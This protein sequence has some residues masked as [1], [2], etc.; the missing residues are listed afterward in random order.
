MNVIIAIDSL[1]GCLTSCQA[2]EAAR[3]AVWERWPDAEVVCLP[4][5]DGGEGFLDA[6]ASL[7]SLHEGGG[8]W[9]RITVEVLDPLM[10]PIQAD[11]LISL[12][13]GE[14]EGGIA[15][16]EL[17]Q[18]SGLA[19]LKP[20][21]RNP[22]IAS[23]YGTGQL[24]ADALRHRPREIVVGLGGSAI[25]DC[26]RGMLEALPSSSFSL[27]KFLIATD[28]TN[29]LLG[30]QGA[31]HTFARQKSAPSLSPQTL[32]AMVDELEARASAFAS[33]SARLLGHDCS[34]EPGAGAAGGVGYALMQYLGAQRLSGIDY[35][36][37]LARFD[38]LLSTADLIITG[39]GHADRQTLMGK[40]P[41]GILRRAKSFTASRLRLPGGTSTPSVPNVI[42]VAGQVSDSEALLSAGFSCIL[43]IT[44]PD[45]PLSEALR[46]EVARRNI[47][48]AIKRASCFPPC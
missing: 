39:E 1:K 17:A 7:V 2:N 33:E 38:D 10:R 26:G 15:V 43:P 22:L 23:S 4:V 24:I 35:V 14:S 45:M 40:L 25:S 46:P 18:A 41:M 20:E 8:S 16:I 9:Q 29:P 48:E 6:V 32:S 3:E 31:A 27:P 11:Y 42:L 28:V 21:E 37:D 44:P 34:R 47:Q 19:L 36:L 12:P 30:P 5:S 13:P